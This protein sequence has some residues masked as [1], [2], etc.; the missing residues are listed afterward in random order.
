M[1][2]GANF[3]VELELFTCPVDTLGC[4][5]WRRGPLRRRLYHLA[6]IVSLPLPPSLS[7]ALFPL[8]SLLTSQTLHP[9]QLPHPFTPSQSHV[10]LTTIPS[11]HNLSSTPF[12]QPL[13]I[14]DTSS[15]T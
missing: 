12:P 13:L 10:S 11:L 9:S 14:S 1:L 15:K 2:R 4:H 5:F 6:Y 7:L 8:S 3:L